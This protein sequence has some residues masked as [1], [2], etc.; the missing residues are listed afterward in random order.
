MK[1]MK[2]AAAVT[3]AGAL[4]AGMAVPAQAKDGRNTAAAIGFGAGALVGAAVA[5][6]NN[7]YYYG[8]RP[9]AY[10]PG[11]AYAPGYM[12]AE[13]AYGAYAYVP[14]SYDSGSSC[15]IRGTYGKGLDYS[16]C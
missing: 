2:F 5:N 3:V 11:Y 7:G 9:Y 16:A 4:A 15:A 8:P 1:M 14:P 10:Q 12:Y 6:A 13:P